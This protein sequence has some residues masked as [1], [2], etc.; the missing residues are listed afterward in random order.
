MIH[1][2]SRAVLLQVDEARAGVLDLTHASGA[3]A[4]LHKGATAHFGQV[5]DTSSP[6]AFF[7]ALGIV[8]TADPLAPQTLNLSNLLQ[9]LVRLHARE[10][11]PSKHG[12]PIAGRILPCSFPH[13]PIDALL[14][15]ERQ[16]SK[17][18]LLVNVT[19]EN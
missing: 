10:A 19:N 11:L 4:L 16:R 2:D 7:P 12:L 14:R 6:T 13:S 1:M 5:R 18:V 15:G 3:V 9:P 8:Y 17:H